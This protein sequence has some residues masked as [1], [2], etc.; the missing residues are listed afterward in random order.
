MGLS[1]V[2]FLLFGCAKPALLLDTSRIDNTTTPLSAIL[3]SQG[4]PCQEK[5]KIVGTDRWTSTLLRWFTPLSADEQGFVAIIDR[6]NGAHH[7]ALETTQK[8]SYDPDSQIL[9]NTVKSS[10]AKSLERIYVESLLLYLQLPQLAEHLYSSTSLQSFAQSDDLYHR[11]FFM[12]ESGGTDDPSI[13]HYV[14]YWNVETKLLD[15]IVF[16][17]RDLSLSYKGVLHY[18]DYQNLLDRKYPMRIAI[19]DSIG[20]SEEIHRIQ[21]TDIACVD[22]G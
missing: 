13:D 10:P 16:T 9:I 17:Y 20:D 8:Y 21:I 4:N 1:M 15:Y 7:L 22:G 11:F 12:R 18:S 19:K 2:F 5:I 6:V 3:Q 14:A